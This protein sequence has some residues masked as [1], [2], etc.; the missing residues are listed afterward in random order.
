MALKAIISKEKFEALSDEVKEHYTEREGKIYLDVTKVEGLAVENVD[1]LKSTVEK[2]RTEKTALIADVKTAETVG[3][4]AVTKFEELK[5]KFDG[6][7]PVLAKSALSK[8]DEIKDWDGETKVR[9][10]VMLAEQTVQSKMQAKL[11]EVVTQNTTKVEGLTKELV[12]SQDQL[13]EA[14]VTSK[15]IEAISKENGNVDVLMPHVR[16]QVVMV[17][18]AHGRFIPEVQKADGTPRIGDSA[19]NDMTITQLVQEM[20][21][22]DTFAGCFKGVNST[23]SGQSGSS[24]AKETSKKTNE[25]V[26]SVDASNTVAVSNSLEDIAVGKTIVNME[27]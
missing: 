1:G 15:I 8:I 26:K 23:G 19:G 9:E 22:Q 18:D 27:K 24:E 10:A 2:L 6:I 13:Q 21:T 25:S 14:V 4:A 12:D 5:T 16:G 20:K 17:K 3:D 11:D 7:D